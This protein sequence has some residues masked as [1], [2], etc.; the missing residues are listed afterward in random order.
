MELPTLADLELGRVLGRGVSGRVLRVRDRRTAASYAL[1]TIEKRHIKGEAQ[2]TNLYREKELLG[3]LSH[4]AIVRFHATLKDEARLYFLLEQLEG[5]ELLW[6]MRRAPHGRLPEEA[7]RRC[8]GALLLPLRYMQVRAWRALPRM[9]AASITHGCSL[10]H[11][12]L[13]DQGV[14]Y[15]DLKPTNVLFSRAGRLKLVDFGHA[16]RLPHPHPNPKPKPNPNPNL[17]PNPDPNLGGGGG[18]RGAPSAVGR[19]WWAA[20]AAPCAGEPKP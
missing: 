4:A 14:L 16:K 17:N 8:L 10:R 3:A 6:H 13:Q 20:A 19:R 5:G 11:V 7:A 12:R 18:G 15:R 2:L 9:A 1:K